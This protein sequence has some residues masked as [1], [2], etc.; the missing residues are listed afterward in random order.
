VKA[1]LT[2]DLPEESCEHEVAVRAMDWALT[3]WDL[4]Q[5]LRDKIKHG[6]RYND[7]DEAL[8]AI[9]GS[10]HEILEDKNLTLEMI[11]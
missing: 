5:W 3:V 7:A 1:I 2:Y 6:H 4:D 11:K 10:L 8:E 9:R